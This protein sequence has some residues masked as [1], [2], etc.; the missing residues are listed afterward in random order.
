MTRTP[1]VLAT[2]GVA[3]AAGVR[4]AVTR[5]TAKSCCRG[6]PTPM[7][8]PDRVCERYARKQGG[9]ISREQCLRAGLTSRAIDGRLQSG[10]WTRW[11]PRI[12]LLPGI[13]PDTRGELTAALL[14]GGEDSVLS[15]G[16][17][18]WV[19]QLEDAPLPRI[20]ELY[21]PNGKIAKRIKAYRWPSAAPIERTS[22][23]GLRVTRVER[24]LADLCSKWSPS[25]VG[26]GMDDAL[27]RGLTSL[28]RLSSE[29]ERARAER[30]RGSALFRHL[31]AGRDHRDS[32]VRSRFETK[33]LRLL[34]EVEPP[35]PDHRVAVSR[36]TYFL[37]FA[38]PHLLV[39]VECQSIRWHLGE[40][41]WK[42]DVARHRR[43]TAAGWIVLF[44]CWDDVMFERDRLKTEIAEALRNRRLLMRPE[45][46][47]R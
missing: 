13:A 16:S 11:L 33:T 9:F 15:H 14:W 42:S 47:P 12:Y 27:R 7:E 35:V 46:L 17:A 3:N 32:K 28:D 20:P 25:F 2:C 31:L 36:D 18:A 40:E 41:A 8:N 5:A 22:V 19:H 1:A 10:G 37:D 21:V 26:R 23:R 39:G 45:L 30:R 6:L 24:T 4:S 38:Y 34:M 43:L 44:V 29:A